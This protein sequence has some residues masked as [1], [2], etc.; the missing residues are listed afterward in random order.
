MEETPEA[1]GKEFHAQLLQELRR[2]CFRKKKFLIPVFQLS[3]VVTKSRV[4]RLVLKSFQ[5]YFLKTLFVT[6]TLLEPMDFRNDGN[7]GREN[8]ENKHKEESV[9]SYQNTFSSCEPQRP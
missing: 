1:Q 5:Q 6:V 3:L 2:L 7:R 8:K 9:L 4:V